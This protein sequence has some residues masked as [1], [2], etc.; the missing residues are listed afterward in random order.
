MKPASVARSWRRVARRT[1]RRAQLWKQVKQT[2]LAI[3]KAQLFQ[4]FTGAEKRNSTEEGQGQTSA[5]GC[6]EVQTARIVLWYSLHTRVQVEL[7]DVCGQA[8][9]GRARAA[10]SI[11]QPAKNK[12][13]QQLCKTV[14]R[15]WRGGPARG[16]P[17]PA[18][19]GSSRCRRPARLLSLDATNGPQSQWAQ[20]RTRGP[21]SRHG[22]VAVQAGRVA[23]SAR[24]PR[25]SPAAAAVRPY[26]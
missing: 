19:G 23:E 17:V 7:A 11:W 8:G 14:C 16:V 22:S 2:A 20:G 4:E 9:G 12:R 3:E 6:K 5:R 15:S 10:V 13:V 26:P 18:A 1:G 25:R 24:Q 21:S